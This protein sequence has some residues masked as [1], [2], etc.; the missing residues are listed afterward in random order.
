MR[1]IILTL[2][3]LFVVFATSCTGD[4]DTPTSE[5][6]YIGGSNGLGLSFEATAPLAEFT[7]DDEVDVR[8]KVINR[9]E[10]EL[11]ENTAKVKLYGVSPTEFNTLSF[12]YFNVESSL[13]PA[14]KDIFEVGGQATVD[15]G[16]ID[17]NG[18]ISSGYIERDIYAKICYP[19]KTKAN[20]EACITS[21]RIEQSGSA[22]ICSHQGEK[23]KDG[24]V[25][26]GPIQIT[27]F[28][29]EPRG[30]DEIIFRIGFQNKRY[31]D[32]NKGQ[33]FSKDA[34]CEDMESS[35]GSVQHDGK[36]FVKILPET[37]L[38]S[39]SNG[40]YSEGFLTL[41]RGEEK[42]L[43]CTMQVEGDSEY[44]QG[45]DIEVDYNYIDSTTT[46]VKIL[47]NQ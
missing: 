2:L 8:L 39:F 13:F 12:D 37:A 18:L 43:V 41:N 19:Y 20:V 47:S 11:L 30:V 15:M 29:E 27:T 32:N 22:N 17:Y 3:V 4:D 16:K 38:C 6:P 5:S 23:V 28:T 44:I 34:G 26:S 31:T 14:E 10:Q 1:K 46:K 40:Q 45:V 35:F 25:S 24:F 7:Q 42:M 36:I 9:G 33:V 21:Q